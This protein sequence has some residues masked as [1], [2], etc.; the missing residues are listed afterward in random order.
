MN[1]IHVR[2][3]TQREQAEGAWWRAIEELRIVSFQAQTICLLFFYFFYF[4][5]YLFYFCWH[6][7]AFLTCREVPIDSLSFIFCR[8]HKVFYVSCKYVLQC[9][10]F[11]SFFLF[12]VFR[13]SIFCGDLVKAQ[14]YGSSMSILLSENVL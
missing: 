7:N 5:W 3:L 12:I 8:K 9:C 2:Q 14:K 4:F 1:S 13:Q 10:F 11:F 6:S